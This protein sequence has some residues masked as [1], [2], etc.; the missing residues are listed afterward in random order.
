ML[1]GL[2]LPARWAAYAAFVMLVLMFGVY[3]NA[4][5]IYFQF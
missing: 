3:Q 5:F 1:S 2:P 4:Q